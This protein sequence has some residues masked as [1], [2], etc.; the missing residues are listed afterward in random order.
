ME[1]YKKCG[2]QSSNNMQTLTFKIIQLKKSYLLGQT[3]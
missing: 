2:P 1:N 3:Q